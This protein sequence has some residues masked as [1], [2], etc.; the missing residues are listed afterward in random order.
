MVTRQG[1]N[2][3]G[4]ICTRK[5]CTVL[6]LTAGH[7][8]NRAPLKCQNVKLDAAITDDAGR[9]YYFSGKKKWHFCALLQKCR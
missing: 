3:L 6:R 5:T 4:L 8:G 9:I 2:T 7:G 1:Y